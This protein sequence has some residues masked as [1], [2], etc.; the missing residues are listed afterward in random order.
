VERLHGQFE[1]H[2]GGVEE[3]RANLQCLLSKADMV[4]CPIDCVSHDACLKVKRFCKQNAKAFIPL[5]SSGLSSFARELTQL[6]QPGR[7]ATHG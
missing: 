7:S 3:S 2:D 4:F 5:H 6:A 1:H